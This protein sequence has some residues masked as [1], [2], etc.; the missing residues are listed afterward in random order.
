MV[1]FKDNISI[2]FYPSSPIVITRKTYILPTP[3]GKRKFEPLLRFISIF[4]FV[5]RR[6]VRT[7]CKRR[8]YLSSVLT[9]QCISQLH[10]P[11]TIFLSMMVQSFPTS[12]NYIF[13]LLLSLATL[14]YSQTTSATTID[15]ASTAVSTTPPTATS[16]ATTAT[17]NDTKEFSVIIIDKEWT[18]FFIGGVP[19][20]GAVVVFGSIY[21]FLWVPWWRA[22]MKDV[23]KEYNR[24]EKSRFGPT[25]RA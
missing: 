20:I 19:I 15:V 21:Q 6:T 7:L 11:L 9:D 23:E 2:F 14:V 16:G 8:A 22:K 4:L 10:V 5:S 1:V 18:Q 17:L 24:L 25:S 3:S 12:Y 13:S